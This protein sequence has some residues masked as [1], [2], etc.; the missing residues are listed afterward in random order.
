MG[1]GAQA[2]PA[3]FWRAS[4]RGWHLGLC[5]LALA[6][7]AGPLGAQEPSAPQAPKQPR[8]VTVHGDRR[9][10]DY[11]W[12][13]DKDKPEV[14]AHLQAEADYT[15]QWFKPHQKLI[16]SLYEELV[17]RI[18]QADDSVPARKGQWWYFNRTQQGQQYP[19][20]LRRPAVGEQRLD[21][22]SSPE[23]VLL[24]LNE[25]A[26][27]RKYL[28]LGGFSVSQDGARL[29]YS[30][31]D[32]GARDYLLM[33]RDLSTGQDM[34]WTRKDVSSFAFSP[35]G[36]H[37]FYITHN[38]SKRS[39]KL[40]RHTLGSAGAD[41]LLFEERDPLY[42]IM[43]GGAGDERH[44]L[45]TSMS[46]DTIEQ[47][48]LDGH[49]P[50]G[51]WQVV[52]P[53]TK[54]REYAV[55]LTPAGQMLLR[56]NDKGPN[57]RL[58]RLPLK[59]LPLRASDLFQARQLMAHN[60]AAAIEGVTVFKTHYV[61]QVREQG[62]VK[63]RLFA[64][65]GGS[66]RD[67]VFPEASYVA[68]PGTNMEADS[69]RM[70]LTYTSLVTPPSTYDVDLNTGSLTLLKRQPVL[71]GF[72]PS[73][74]ATERL[75]ATAKDGTQVPISIVYAK[76]KRA[77]GPQALLLRGYGSYGIPSDPNFRM[78][79]LSLLD[80]GVIVGIAHIRGGGDLGRRWYQEGKLAK[81]MNTFTDFIAVAEQLIRQGYTQPSQLII[82]GGSAGGLLMGAVTNLR[83]DLFKAVV[84]DV[85][86]VD[87]INTMLDETLP[88]TTEEFIEWGNP[89]V[90]AEYQWM[91]AYS[92]YDNLKPGA[93]PAILARTGLNDS[94]V[95][96]WEPAKYVAKLRTL[97][98]NDTPLLFDINMNAGHGGASGRFD[99]LKERARVYAFMLS[100][101]GLN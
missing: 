92:P 91:R 84:A 66:G 20:F 7:T 73:R 61:V 49:R 37:L 64:H 98:T 23:Q 11:F 90:K 14:I 2:S 12:L 26:K 9:I 88:L 18:Q 95:P 83:P 53:R 55:Q 6:L 48:L 44:L 4:V 89:K 85:P 40:W 79:D 13:R 28:S 31:D 78:S 65:A 51:P 24:D 50:E 72:D 59:K 82:N 93:Y 57:Y 60:D 29:A 70:R 45:L 86:F 63:Q 17:G 74:Y 1:F 39:D 35:D 99:A 10:D 58:V 77:K 8:D 30:I 97:K 71:G 54:G 96:Y 27:G 21:S 67:V 38:E 62:S 42:N 5:L 69:D 22:A 87:V 43:L 101:W 16:D 68:M 3:S 94:Q 34:A 75:M 41:V 33:V 15:A 19:L 46:K 36:R 80:R 81:K 32:T 76:D 52:L 47:H 100:Q 56:I 25:L